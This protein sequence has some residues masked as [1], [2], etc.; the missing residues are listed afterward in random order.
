MIKNKNWLRTSL[1]R[2]KSFNYSLICAEKDV[3]CGFY[4]KDISCKRSLLIAVC[5]YIAKNDIIIVNN[6]TRT[7][8]LKVF[9]LKSVVQADR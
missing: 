6:F 2:N 3:S 7:L 8:Y 1:S 4:N 9:G 5:N